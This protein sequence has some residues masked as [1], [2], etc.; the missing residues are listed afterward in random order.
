MVL[1]SSAKYPT[2]WKCDQISCRGCASPVGNYR[3]CWRGYPVSC[4]RFARISKF[5]DM[6]HYSYYA[7]IYKIKLIH[8]GNILIIYFLIFL[9]SF[10]MC[11]LVRD[12]CCFPQNVPNRS[13]PSSL[14]PFK[15]F[16]VRHHLQSNIVTCDY[17]LRIINYIF[18]NRYNT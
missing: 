5:R 17:L 12:W 2:I 9:H 13:I 14:L 6:W 7:R 8:N 11:T 1:C 10:D 15:M 16:L 3:I 4:G 18:N